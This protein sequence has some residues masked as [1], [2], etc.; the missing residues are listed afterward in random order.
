MSEHRL[1]RTPIKK[2]PPGNQD[3]LSMSTKNE[4]RKLNT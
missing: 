3:E 1:A 2:I 4:L